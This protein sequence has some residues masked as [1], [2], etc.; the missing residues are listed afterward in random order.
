MTTRAV[1]IGIA[2]SLETDAYI[3]AMQRMVSRRGRTAHIWSDN[4]TNFVG[5]EKEIQE[6]HER[7]N[8]AKITD[9][10]SQHGI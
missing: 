3:M 1:L 5:A 8:E 6:A 7:L 9:E 2:H 10:L 4:G